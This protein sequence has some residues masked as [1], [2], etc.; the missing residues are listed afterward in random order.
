[1]SSVCEFQRSIRW[2]FKLAEVIVEAGG[3]YRY[4]VPGLCLWVCNISAVPS[5]RG[6]W[7]DAHG[8]LHVLGEVV[9]GGC[10]EDNSLFAQ[11]GVGNPDGPVS[12]VYGLRVD[13]R[14]VGLVVVDEIGDVIVYDDASVGECEVGIVCI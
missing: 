10:R 4:G 13:R 3:R 9:E 6:T 5:D 7:E 11:G 2:W 8:F 12:V 14:G 1:V